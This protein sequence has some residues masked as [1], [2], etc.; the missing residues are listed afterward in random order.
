MSNCSSSNHEGFGE[1]Q[2][3]Q[4]LT[5]ES[6]ENE[7]DTKQLEL[8]D[9]AKV[10]DL[11]VSRQKRTHHQL[12][13]CLVRLTTLAV[14]SFMGELGAQQSSR[15]RAQGSSQSLPS[16]CVTTETCTSSTRAVSDS[17]TDARADCSD[18]TAE[19]LV[20]WR[21]IFIV[22]ILSLIQYKMAEGQKD[23]ISDTVETVRKGA[24]NPCID[25]SDF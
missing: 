12:L 25:D 17:A 1:W 13:P 10:Y 20:I 18:K 4:L 9:Q 22:V 8:K 6:K 14:V 2:D 7:C 5:V 23:E 19:R 24:L 21:Y 11:L 16:P 3:V 15:I